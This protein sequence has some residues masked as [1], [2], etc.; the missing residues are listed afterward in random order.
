MHFFASILSLCLIGFASYSPASIRDELDRKYVYHDTDDWEER[1]QIP[2]SLEVQDHLAHGRYQEAIWIL[3][4]EARG[5]TDASRELKKI[6]RN[7]LEHAPVQPDGVAPLGGGITKTQ[8]LYL[9]NGVRGVFKKHTPNPA[10]NFKSEI[11]A[12]LIDQ[13]GQFG[14][15][16]MT[17]LRYHDGAVGSLQYFVSN[18]PQAKKVANYVKSSRM[19]AFDYVIRNQDRKSANVVVLGD[20]EIAIDH[21]LSLRPGCFIGAF[22]RTMDKMCLAFHLPGDQ[23][24]MHFIFPSDDLEKFRA[25]QH[26]LDA[27]RKLTFPQVVAKLHPLLKMRVI[28]MFWSKRTNLLRLLDAE[29]S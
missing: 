7:I 26:V 4:D 11:G 24:R 15:V 2:L 23:L 22:L 5:E 29:P 18:A 3:E 21:S 13:L 14:L 19:Y 28:R 10:S 25:D 1:L 12:Y 20:R 16:P 6:L 8:V 9:T 17:V 27:L